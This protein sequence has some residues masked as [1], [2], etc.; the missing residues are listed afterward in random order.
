[1]FS[2]IDHP[3]TQWSNIKLVQ[4]SVPQAWSC[5]PS[6]ARK[7]M[8][9]TMK[10]SELPKFT[11]SP[12]MLMPSPGAVCPASVQLAR[13]TRRLLLRRISPFTANTMVSGSPG[14]W[15]KAHRSVPSSSVSANDV[16]VTT[17]PPRPPVAYLPKPSA[18]GK[19][20]GVTRMATASDVAPWRETVLTLY[21][22]ALPS[23]MVYSGSATKASKRPLRYI[24]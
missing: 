19:A 2:S 24:R 23:D 6:P 21:S 18:V 7:R 9:R 13:F 10:F 16:T 17:F 8:L 15:L 1:M 5:L 14:Y 12:T 4:F 22:S 20:T 3:N 11:L